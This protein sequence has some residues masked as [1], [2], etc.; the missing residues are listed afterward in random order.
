MEKLLNSKYSKILLGIASIIIIILILRV[1]KSDINID[2]S[3][4]LPLSTE[5]NIK[6]NDNGSVSVMLLGN[7]TMNDRIR[8]SY[9][10][11][12]L[13]GIVETSLAEKIETSD[14][15]IIS[16][17]FT[18]NGVWSNNYASVS[19]L[20]IFTEL[21]IN[22]TCLSNKYFKALADDTIP[23]TISVLSQ[24]GIKSA[25]ASTSLSEA[26]FPA[27]YTYNSKTIGLLS[28]TKIPENAS[29]AGF[30]Q[31]SN[32]HIKPVS[33]IYG[34]HDTD[35]LCT[36]IKNAKNKCN[37]LIVYATF[38]DKSS[39]AD[40]H[41]FIEAGADIVVGCSDNVDG[42]E[43]YKDKPIIYG[44]GNFLNSV[45]AFD[46]EAV[47]LNIKKDN[48]CSLTVIPCVSD[49]YYVKTLKDSDKNEFL[50]N[51]KDMSSGVKISKKGVITH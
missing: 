43:Y 19:D 10:S 20:K 51:L 39:K 32:G 7:V 38:D 33:G 28:L 25:G 1:F 2:S 49:A 48:S 42:I 46:T 4:Q 35:D 45:Q 24:Y 9:N 16:Q 18:A 47:K 44:I 13:S 11:K 31:D 21:G 15:A 40:A 23:S 8:T 5:E 12:E 26:A 50:S 3:E 41:K 30:A 29:E 37:F 34:K 27:T 14:I 22:M 6:T 36:N 17:C